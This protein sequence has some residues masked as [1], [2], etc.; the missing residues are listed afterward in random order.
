MNFFKKIAKYFPEE[1]N[2]ITPLWIVLAV[3]AIIIRLIISQLGYNFDIASW[4]LVGEIVSNGGVVYTETYR[5][6]TGPVWCY[7]L[8]F[9]Y[10][11][12]QFLGLSSI[13]SYH[14]IIA[15]FLSL[16]DVAIALIISKRYNLLWGTLFLFNPISILITGF[17]SQ[18]DNIAVL[19]A[20]I[21]WI[22]IKQTDFKR[23]H[24][25]SAI[26]VGLSLLTKHIFVFYPLWLF[27][28][29][30][31]IKLKD[32]LMHLIVPYLVFFLG[33]L[34]FLINPE[35]RISVIN[36]VFKYESFNGNGLIAY[37]FNFF[38]SFIINEALGWIPIFSGLKFFFLIAM[39][40]TGYYSAKS[41]PN[42]LFPLYLISMIVFTTAIADQYFIIPCLA[43]AMYFRRWE[44]KAFM[45]A[46]SFHLI[47]ISPTN[48]SSWF[49]PLLFHKN[50]AYSLLSSFYYCIV[51]IKINSYNLINNFFQF[52]E[53]FDTTLVHDSVQPSSSFIVI[54]KNLLFLL[55]TIMFPI[56]QFWL[57]IFIFRYLFIN[58]M[59]KT[60]IKTANVN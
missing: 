17:H 26:L 7:M 57:A 32:R 46:A 27:F 54:L 22:I 28:L 23:G 52:I 31:K 41:K 9:L 19:I 29:N 14:F 36:H 1:S 8:A 43:C 12:H 5:Y 18:F 38:P 51:E 59:K 20:L 40:I 45:I 60:Q 37:L 13:Q 42:E 47:F 53:G 16:I 30:D 11:I 50:L 2:K 25:I 39:V 58:K 4:G 6:T 34:P 21:S 48:I 3:I 35:I 44:I 24:L 33:F 10:K 55:R 15:F 49:T 56:C